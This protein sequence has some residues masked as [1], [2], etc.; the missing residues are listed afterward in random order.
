M[1]LTSCL[2]EAARRFGDATAYRAENGLEL[3]YA[4]LHRLS[5]EVAVGLAERGIGPGDVLA[6]AL[7]TIPEYFVCYLAAA[8]IGAVTAGVNTRLSEV[9]QQAV[10]DVA[11][12]ALVL[13]EADVGAASKVDDMLSEWRARGASPTP[14]AEDPDRPVALVF[15]SGTTGTPKGVLF[16]NRQLDA[17]TAIDVGDRWGG[18]P[19][20]LAS[21]SLAHLGP[22]TK[23]AGNLRGGGTT[24]L[25]RRWSA[26]AALRA[27]ADHGVSFLGG[28][29]TQVALM[30]E[31][32][33][34]PETDLS[35]VQAIVVGGGPA[36]P[37]LVR[38]ARARFGVPLAVRYSCTEAAIGCGTKFDDPPEDA[39]VSVGRAQ[40]GVT[41]SVLDDDD[42]PVPAGEVGHVCLRSGA[43]MAG[44]WNDPA[45]TAAAFTAD[46]SVRT[47]DLG[48]I[49]D[50]GR[51]HL[52]GRSKEMYVRGG[53]NV[54]PQEVEA[55]LAE[56]P[57]VVAVCVVSRPDDVMGEVGVAF[58]V[59]RS[60]SA[61]PTLDSL[62]TFGSDRLAAYKLPEDLRI[63]DA[64]PLTSM[65][66][67]D[68][69]ALAARLTSS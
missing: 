58:V 17:V 43:V 20:A 13:R 8:R 56:H 11:K 61:P 36:T 22:M 28:I 63:V 19:R 26:G 21:T 60:A 49:D 9:E 29:P 1:T 41:L 52:A 64:L 54:H 12:P 65:D 37:A 16:C 18:G 24:F 4:D 42:K 46:G 68:R 55:V 40:A 14:L 48:W 67:V 27:V 32:P 51:L 2:D 47:G 10:L 15:T 33:T 69:R 66:K 34:L 5:G 45:A 7:P 39:E 62:R 3:S 35:S 23:L 59:P 6:L 31:H 53:Y 38:A 30:L 25:M 50:R 57:E 44:Y